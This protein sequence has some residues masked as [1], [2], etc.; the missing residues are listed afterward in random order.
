MASAPSS[1]AR[2]SAA[3]ATAGR[4]SPRRTAMAVWTAPISLADAA[5]TWPSR[6]QPIDQG[7]AQDHDV[8]RLARQQA[9]RHAAHG[10]EGAVDPPAG[11]GFERRAKDFDQPLSRAAA[12]DPDAL[13]CALMPACW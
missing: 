6:G 7:A 13:H 3:L 1:A 5:T 4:G 12:Q 11:L 9:G 8:G 2:N 10:S